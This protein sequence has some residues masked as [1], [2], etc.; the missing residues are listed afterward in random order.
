[1]FYKPWFVF[2]VQFAPRIQTMVCYTG[3]K[4]LPFYKAWFGAAR[5]RLRCFPIVA[6]RFNLAGMSVSWYALRRRGRALAKQPQVASGKQWR[7]DLG[8]S[9]EWLDKAGLSVEAAQVRAAH[10]RRVA[11]GHGEDDLSRDSLPKR[12]RAA[13]SSEVCSGGAYVDTPDPLVF[14]NDCREW[15][16]NDSPVADWYADDTQQDQHRTGEGV[17]WTGSLLRQPIC[18]AWDSGTKTMIIPDDGR[19]VF[20][21]F[22]QSL[23][24][25]S[26]S[27]P[28]DAEYW[29]WFDD[30]SIQP[31]AENTLR[32]CVVTTAA[33]EHIQ[34]LTPAAI[35]VMLACRH[36]FGRDALPPCVRD[37]R[38]GKSTSAAVLVF[39]VKK[40]KMSRHPSFRSSVDVVDERAPA[41]VEFFQGRPDHGIK[42]SSSCSLCHTIAQQRQTALC[43]HTAGTA[44]TAACP[45]TL[46]I[47]HMFRRAARTL[48]MPDETVD[49]NIACCAVR[50]TALDPLSDGPPTLR[51][52]HPTD[53]DHEEYPLIYPGSDSCHFLIVQV[54]G[55]S[56]F[57]GVISNHVT[58]G[59]R[60]S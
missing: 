56:K 9:L 29:C 38:D 21:G 17:R 52:R 43:S 31:V 37:R 30:H 28:G 20:H 39:G 35:L 24:E 36:V 54:R 51:H 50:G 58:V 6:T 22:V 5:K 41:L 12:R 57:A 16:D 26:N 25:G 60:V 7:D 23:V 13:G 15:F 19:Q 8:R 14:D 48:S 46:A 10:G 55:Y 45:H 42:S 3:S 18:M 33:S 47:R 27:A 11:A 1:M 59:R 40:M 2:W 4:L 49:S 44:S 32:L 34:P 53:Q